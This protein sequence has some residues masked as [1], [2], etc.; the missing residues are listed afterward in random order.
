MPWAARVPAILEAWYPGR[1]GGKAIANVLTGRVNP[2]GHLPV[3]FYAQRSA[4]SASGA[5]R[6]QNRDGPV[7]PRLFRRRGGRLQM[8]RQE[9]SAAAVPVRARPQLHELRATARSA[10]PPTPTARSTCASRS[11]IPASGAGMAVGQVYASPAARRVGSAASAS[12]GSRRWTSRRGSRSRSMSSH[13]PAPARDFDEAAQ[14]WRIAPG[15]YTLTR[16]RLI[17]RFRGSTTVT[18]PALTSPLELAPGTGSAAPRQRPGER[19]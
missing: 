10:Q 13:R 14:A 16:R 19:G 12:S 2:S 8:V 15:A 18:L 1:A 11:A 7:P 17:A 4:A 6:R 3:T 9:Q 5:P